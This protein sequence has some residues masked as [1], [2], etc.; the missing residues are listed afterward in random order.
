MAQNKTAFKLDVYD[1]V[2]K[3]EFQSIDGDRSVID[4][5]YEHK[6]DDEHE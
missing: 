6:G 4:E 1:L 3:E 5:V 2:S